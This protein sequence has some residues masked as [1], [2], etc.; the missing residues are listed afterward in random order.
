M[1]ALSAAPVDA[2]QLQ[3]SFNEGRVTLVAKGVTVR[4]IMTE[5]ARVGGTAITG[6]DALTGPA[7]ALELTDVPETDALQQLLQSAS[8]YVAA[9]RRAAAPGISYFDRIVI[10]AT[11]RA[12][13]PGPP[14]VA[15]R[16]RQVQINMPEEPAPN[17]EPLLLIVTPSAPPAAPATPGNP[18]APAAAPPQGPTIELVPP[19]GEK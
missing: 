2:Q 3:M 12:P 1:L 13:E 9:P 18:F 8:G 5:W 6:G 19:S 16:Q 10:V 15:D 17:Q 7:V 11:S 4:F 14:T